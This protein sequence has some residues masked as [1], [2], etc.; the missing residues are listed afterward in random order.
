MRLAELAETSV[1]VA[2][3]RG[4]NAK[5]AVLEA[6]LRRLAPDETRLALAFLAGELPAGKLGVGWATVQE[7][8]TQLPP[9]PEGS[10]SPALTTVDGVLKELR[11]VAGAGSAK[12]RKEL[13]TALVLPLTPVERDFL[14]AVFVG[15]VRQGALAALVLEAAAAVAGLPAARLRRAAML[16]GSEI[17]AAATAL[18]EGAPGLDRF[19]LAPF[20]PILPMLASPAADAQEAAGALGEARYELKLDGARLQAHKDGD[21]VRLY[22]RS[23]HDVTARAPELV[24]VVRALPAR[25]LILDGEALALRPDGRPQPFQ[26]SMSR[27]GRSQ[28]V[29]EQRARLGL[30]PFFFDVL[31]HDDDVLL[32][33]PLTQ[34]A[35]RLEQLVAPAHRPLALVTAD[36]DAADAFYADALARGHEGLVAKSLAAPYDAGRRGQAWLKLKPA[37]TVDLVVLGVERGSGRR[38]AWLSNLHLGARDAARGGFAMVGKTFKG[39]TDAMLAWQ[40]ERFTALAEGPAD[41][42]VVRVRP[43][44][45]VE[46]AFND[47]LRSTEYPSG[48]ALRFARVRRYREDKGPLDATTLAELEALLPA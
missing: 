26:V 42:W 37:H 43:E 5:Q 13:L 41:G 31:L 15:N 16:A 39:M 40:T 44:Q 2:Q 18:T 27:F 46:I 45:V 28:D 24:E 12:R 21:E 6:C 33:A 19:T 1:R 14:G 30:T 23:L 3:E 35:A 47:V 25:R 7:L 9:A 11:G 20:H 22:S 29:A 36:A 32:D 38:S 8:L 10:T 4:R 34:R 48:V 17:E